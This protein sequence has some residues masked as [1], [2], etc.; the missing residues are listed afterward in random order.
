MNDK[1]VLVP[2]HPFMSS[3]STSRHYRAQESRW[4]SVPWLLHTLHNIIFLLSCFKFSG[5]VSCTN[6]DID[7]KGHDIDSMQ[8]MSASWLDCLGTCKKTHNCVSVTMDLSGQYNGKTGKTNY[9]YLKYKKFDPREGASPVGLISANLDCFDQQDLSDFVG[10]LNCSFTN[11]Q[12]Q[13]W[14]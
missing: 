1:N 5:S 4:C 9:C 7:F 6:V 3:L 12:R 11:D 8:F 2:N 10:K 14:T 13:K